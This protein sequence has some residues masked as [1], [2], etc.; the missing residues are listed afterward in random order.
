MVALEGSTLDIE[1]LSPALNIVGFE[2]QPANV[3][4]SD[5]V[6]SA[7]VTLKQP[8]LLFSLPSAAKCSP[9]SIKV[10][11]PLAEHDDHDHEHSKETSHDRE[12]KTHSD[13]TGHY[14]FQ[15]SDMSVL[16][17]IAIEIFKQFPGIEVI[18]VQSI[19]QQG[20]QKLE[21]SPDHNI[22]EL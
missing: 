22:L 14:S 5:A 12:E 17:R 3:A 11:S 18:G 21:L 4:Q 2:H 1:L 19:S 7:I 20:Q 16:D 10:E 8:G 6:E 15:C 13:F 9:V